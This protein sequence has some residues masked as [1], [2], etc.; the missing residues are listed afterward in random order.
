MSTRS[1]Q[2]G[3]VRGFGRSKRTRR[4][5]HDEANT[6]IAQRGSLKPSR[7]AAEV[8]KPQTGPIGGRTSACRK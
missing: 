8:P 1:S 5:P 6:L 7:A 3:S 2:F 4:H